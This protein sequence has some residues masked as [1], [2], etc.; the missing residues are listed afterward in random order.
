MSLCEDNCVFI[1]YDYDNGNAICECGVKTFLSFID[2]IKI[3]R[4][5]LMK[6]FKEVKNLANI[7]IIKCYKMVFEKENLIKNYGFFILCSILLLSIICKILFCLKYYQSLINEINEIIKAKKN[8][9]QKEKI[10]Y[11]KNNN[12]KMSKTLKINNSKGLNQSNNLIQSLKLNKNKKTKKTGCF[13]PK[14]KK[15]KNININKNLTKT[16]TS[17]KYHTTEGIVS[18]NT[19][20]KDKKILEFNDYE[21]NSLSYKDALKYDQR[22]Y[23]NYYFSLLRKNNLIAFSFFPNNDYNSQIIKIFLF[24]FFFASNLIITALFFNDDTMH[25]IYLDSG[26]FNLN[27]QIPHCV[28]SSLIAWVINIIIRYFAL[29]EKQVILIKQ[30]KSINNNEEKIK[31][32]KDELKRKFIIFFIVS[33]VFLSLFCFYISCFC[34]IYVNTQILLIEDSLFG[35]GF[36]LIYPFFIYLI[37]GMFR[38]PALKAKK[39]NKEYLYK[40][41]KI[42]QMI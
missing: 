24:F 25:K 27:Y 39:S 5:N 26:K 11:K 41:S 17:Q 20:G 16:N 29:S 35:F 40:F 6:N 42:I 19:K 9:T 15:A 14:K 28:Y 22:T 31:N 36:S 33:F 10:Q 7:K 3:D 1:E 30:M 23:L 8:L 21:L 18:K 38:L 37:P 12:K 34:C 2:E 32:I 4:N 13:P